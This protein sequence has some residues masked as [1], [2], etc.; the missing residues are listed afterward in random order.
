M[1]GLGYLRLDVARGG[2]SGALLSQEIQSK[3]NPRYPRKKDPFY[4]KRRNPTP[5]KV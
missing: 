2:S 5:Q 3:L 1:A 4:R